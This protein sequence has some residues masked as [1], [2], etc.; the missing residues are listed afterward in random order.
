MA[1]GKAVR[2]IP[3]ISFQLEGVNLDRLALNA[4]VTELPGDLVRVGEVLRGSYLSQHD[5]HKHSASAVTTGS[6]GPIRWPN[7]RK[8][9][10][11]NLAA[12]RFYVVR[13][14]E[15]VVFSKGPEDR[16]KLR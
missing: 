16:T 5:R 3:W 2:R 10:S 13:E 1:E 12:D 4:R 11:T 7:G 9:T 14:G 15:G 6:A 8:D